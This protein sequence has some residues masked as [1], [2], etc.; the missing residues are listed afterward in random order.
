MAFFS[1]DVQGVTTSTFTLVRDGTT[2]PLSAT[3]SYSYDTT[4]KAWKA[5]LNPASDLR[6]CTLYK[7]TV[8][9]GVK[10][11]VGNALDQD[12]AKAGNQP[13]VWYFKTGLQ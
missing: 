10:D 9:T 2:T 5:T 11:K 7:A 4:A 1:E 13:K 6:K 12:P 3:V 8:T